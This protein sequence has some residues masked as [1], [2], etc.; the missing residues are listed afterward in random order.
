MD[1]TRRTI[2]CSGPLS[3]VD[4]EQG[5]ALIIVLLML[6]LL[7]ILGTTLFSSSVETFIAHEEPV[8]LMLLTLENT[9]GRPRHLSV[10][11]YAAWAL[12]PPRPDAPRHVVTMT[13]QTYSLK[14]VSLMM[15]LMV[16]FNSALLSWRATSLSLSAPPQS[17]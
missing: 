7:I 16:C 11:A 12:G 3:R 2:G 4:N 9:S 8:K 14:R 15:P 10:F 6:L 17:H 13:N 5:S 1:Q